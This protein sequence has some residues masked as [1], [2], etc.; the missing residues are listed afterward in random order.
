MSAQ[1]QGVLAIT[2]EGDVVSAR[3]AARQA[4]LALGFGLTDVTRIVTAVSELA[5]NVFM[6]AG[7]GEMR[8]Q[9]VTSSGQVG[10]E[11]MFADEGPGIADIAQVL[12]PGYSTSGGLGMGL[13]GAKRLMDDL[14]IQSTVGRGTT[15]LTRKW[16]EK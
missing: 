4:A 14:E 16:R 10:L 9:T 5:R 2:S 6:Y 3:Q 12:T 1:P 15:V 8:W 11:L 7:Q 13:P